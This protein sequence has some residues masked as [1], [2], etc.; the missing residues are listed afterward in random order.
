MS[1]SAVIISSPESDQPQRYAYWPELLEELK[2]LDVVKTVSRIP[3]TWG[4]GG[5]LPYDTWD[6]YG[7]MILPADT[8]NGAQDLGGKVALEYFADSRVH[9]NLANWVEQGGIFFCEV[10]SSGGRPHQGSY[11]AIFGASALHVTDAKTFSRWPVESGMPYENLSKKERLSTRGD[12]ALTSVKFHGHPICFGIHPFVGNGY[13]YFGEE[14]I[15]GFHRESRKGQLSLYYRCPETLYSGWFTDW[16]KD[17]IPILL[18]SE[19]GRWPVLLV[20]IEGKGAW[21]ASTVRLTSRAAIPLVRN[22]LYFGSFRECWLQYHRQTSARRKRLDIV[23]ILAVY[24]TFT[25][26]A[27]LLLHRFGFRRSVEIFSHFHTASGIS[28][29]GIV[30]LLGGFAQFLYSR[31]LGHPGFA[32]ALFNRLRERL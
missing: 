32:R 10:Q 20:R 31:P 4:A 13:A 9:R 25:A 30:L 1:I 7:V 8:A 11:D 2:Y 27:I 3:A 16:S 14:V 21:V 19:T 12:I 5:T 28:I 6:Q 17:W 24:L 23:N 18:E 22:I 15:P 26:A 29:V